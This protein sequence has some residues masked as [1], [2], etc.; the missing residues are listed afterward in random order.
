[1]LTL[2][3]QYH[4]IFF[5]RQEKISELFIWLFYYHCCPGKMTAGLGNNHLN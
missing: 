5:E 2:L 3:C 4:H 1:M